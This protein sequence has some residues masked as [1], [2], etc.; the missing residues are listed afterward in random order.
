MLQNHSIILW[1]K[2]D[3]PRKT[4]K[5]IAEEAFV[6]LSVFQNFPRQFRPNYIAIS[7]VEKFQEVKWNYENFEK[8]LREGINKENNK[9]FENLGY[10]IQMFSSLID[11]ESFSI[12]LRVGNKESIF[13][14]TL[15][16]EIPNTMNMLDL[17]NAELI[18]DLFN[19]L[20]Q[21]FVPFWGCVSNKA[22]MRKYKRY[23]IN[24]KPTTVH[25]LNYWGEDIQKAIGHEYIKD[26]L[27]KYS[28]ISFERNIFKIQKKSFDIEDHVSMEFHHDVEK[29][30]RLGI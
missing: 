5:Q 3:D 21:G 6:T 22:M 16:V 30:L 20:A 26:T 18:S 11:V 25:W 13:Y 10:S 9:T 15:V 17:N 12:Q 23:L 28:D 14:N 8:I 19:Q 4:F 1:R 2:S 24:G 27:E 29:M 7:S